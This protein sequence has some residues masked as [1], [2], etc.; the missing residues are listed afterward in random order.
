[1]FIYGNDSDL[2]IDIYQI[3]ILKCH[4]VAENCS[5]GVIK[6]EVEV[7]GTLAIFNYYT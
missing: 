7:V 4:N 2:E 3:S 6:W 1:M 5:I